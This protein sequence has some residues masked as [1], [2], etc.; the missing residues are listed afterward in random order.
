M[1]GL[2]ATLVWHPTAMRHA[3]ASYIDRWK[4]VYAPFPVVQDSLRAWQT[5][6]CN[7][8]GGKSIGILLYVG[9]TGQ[10]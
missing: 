10:W 3:V 5:A 4:Q 1:T 9:R 7:V 2:G 8:A 6:Q